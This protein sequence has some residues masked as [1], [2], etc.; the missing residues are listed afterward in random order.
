M[1][2]LSVFRPSSILHQPMVGTPFADSVVR[3]FLL[4]ADHSYRAILEGEAVNA[5]PRAARSRSSR[6]NRTGRGPCRRWLHAAMSALVPCSMHS[7]LTSVR[8]PWRT[9]ARYGCAALM[10]TCSN[11]IHQSRRSRRSLFVGDL[12][13]W[14]VSPPR[15]RPA[16]ARTPPSPCS[17]QPTLQS[18]QSRSRWSSPAGLHI[19]R[20]VL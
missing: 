14:D 19:H 1:N 7:V 13:I 12:P 17:G 9:C 10:T 16:M 18:D 15:M 2:L 5:P 4:A 11:P 8:H 20:K 6:P 3:G